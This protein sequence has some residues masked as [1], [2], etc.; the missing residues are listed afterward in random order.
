MK[1]IYLD[2]ASTT[3]IIPEV[4][5]VMIP[6]LSEYFGN[7][8]AIYLEGRNSRM[9]V[10]NA[11]KEIA[12]CLSTYPSQII[13]TSGGTEANNL[14]LGGVIKARKIIVVISSPIEHESVL[15]TLYD[16]S[17]DGL[18]KLQM[19]NITI[20]GVPDYF[21]LE[22]LFQANVNETILVSLMHGNNE[23]GSMIDLELV[24]KLSKRYRAYFHTNAVQTIAYYPMALS[25]SPFD[26][27]SVSAHKFHGPKGIGFIWV[28]KDIGLRTMQT[29]GSHENGM[30]AGAEHVAGI[31]GMAKS[32]RL[33]ME[34][35]PAAIQHIQQL[36][37]QLR[38]GLTKIGGRVN[39]MRNG[40]GLYSILNMCFE[41]RFQSHNLLVELD[42]AGIAV[43][44]SVGQ[45]SQ[46]L[47]K[48]E[49]AIVS[50]DIISIRFSF[51]RFNTSNEIFRVLSIM[52]Y[53]LN[54]YSV[55][56]KALPT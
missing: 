33:S 40:N 38:E 56:K 34:S 30:R 24:G 2:N 44:S 36:Y 12:L 7:P 55:F 23:T 4:V 37:M 48:L 15:K 18:I 27:L 17:S 3:P 10:E 28:R 19:V 21:H 20:E 9:A 52:D 6:Y 45:S 50:D 13:F 26:L 39:G 22:S 51:S 29:G 11:R 42:S 53:Q 46:V 54:G 35:Y 1:R 25:N 47:S 16:L 49:T 8:S 31:V 32:F 5:D 14:A 43:E 41:N